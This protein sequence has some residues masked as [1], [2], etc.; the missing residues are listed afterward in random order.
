M[1]D[2]KTCT[3]CREVFPATT[4]YFHERKDSKSGIRAHCKSCSNNR[5]KRWYSGNKERSRSNANRWQKQNPDKCREYDKKRILKQPYIIYK[6]VNTHS[7]K[8]YI[9]E[10]TYG[11]R[12]WAIHRSQLIGGVHPNLQLQEDWDGYGEEAFNFEIIEEFP[13]DLSREILHEKEGEYI[14]QYL[15]EGKVLYNK[16]RRIN[17]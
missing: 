2:T 10:S 17:V 1:S 11:K 15:K 14:N 9:G 13:R 16:N 6:I 4:E 7:S 5:S 3:K 8:I 12:R